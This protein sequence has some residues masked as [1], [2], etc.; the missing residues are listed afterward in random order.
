MTLTLLSQVDQKDLWP[1]I[2]AKL[3]FVHFPGNGNE[4]GKAGPALAAHL[5][6]I[7]KEFLLDFDTQ[8]LRQLFHHRRQLAAQYQKNAAAGPSAMDGA[9]SMQNGQGVP[10]GLDVK[11]PKVVNELISNAHLSVQEMQQRGVSPHLIQLVDRHRDTLKSM[12]EQQRAFQRN[13]QTASQQGGAVPQCQPRNVS[14]PMMNGM[15]MNGVNAM[16]NGQQPG[17]NLQNGLKPNVPM[18]PQPGMPTPAMQANGQPQPQMGA[19]GPQGS[20]SGVRSIHQPLQN[21]IEMVRKL[22]EENKRTYCL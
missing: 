2:G 4:P 5:E 13:I 1:V 12:L 7:Y 11:D 16:G 18:G 6:H 20:S 3:G 22:R 19:N 15:Q 8:Y 14:N 17:M 10:Q 9:M 21:A